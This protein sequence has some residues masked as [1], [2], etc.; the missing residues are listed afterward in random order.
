[1]LKMDLEI[2]GTEVPAETIL[3]ISVEEEVIG[4]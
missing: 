3:V 1:M 4:K 2:E